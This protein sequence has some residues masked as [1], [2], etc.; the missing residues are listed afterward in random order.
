ML[1]EQAQRI[2]F[3]VTLAI[4]IIVVIA[5][6]AVLLGRLAQPRERTLS[7]L[8][9]PGDITL[10]QRQQV[11]FVVE[12]PLED[13]QWAATGGTI[14]ADGVYIAGDQPGD[15]EV[16]ADGSERQHGRAVVHIV[17]CTPT[18]PPL[19]TP[20][21]APTPTPTAVPTP[22]PDADA[23]GDVG[24]YSSG[25]P[26]AQFP[27]GLDIRN[28][29]IRADLSLD[30]T[31]A[32]L[33]AELVEWAEEGETVLWIALY[34]PIPDTLPVRTDW[35]F[36]LDLDGNIETGR[37]AGEARINPDIGMEI[38][39]GLYYETDDGS[40]NPYLLVWDPRAA[41]WAT[42]SRGVFMERCYTLGPKR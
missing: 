11:A 31:D 14:R 42:C 5:V 41:D 33:P 28:A 10:C 36:A 2:L 13:V 34:D 20:T 29:S 15:Y 25:S 27:G 23:R 7:L 24:L 9:T 4:T 6:M 12:P 8:I 26:A 40:F 22:I 38:A 30:L 32:A 16:L 37:P 21:L 1:N 19:P 39:V 3:W 35:L 17:V 18:I